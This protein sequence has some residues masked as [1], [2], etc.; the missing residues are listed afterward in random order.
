LALIYGFGFGFGRLSKHYCAIAH[1][2]MP[3]DHYLLIRTLEHILKNVKLQYRKPKNIPAN[4]AADNAAQKAGK[5]SYSSITT[6]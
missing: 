4:Y 6:I 5:E 3:K 2:T 1:F